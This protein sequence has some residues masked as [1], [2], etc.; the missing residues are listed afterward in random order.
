MND[1]SAVRKQMTEIGDRFLRR[2]IGEV[3]QL[4]ALLQQLRA[5]DGAALKEI[6]IIVHRIHGS[7]AIFGFEA[8]SNAA[9]ECERL[10]ATETADPQIADKMAVALAGLETHLTAAARARTL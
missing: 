3:E 7:G 4:G 8:V 6:E 1:A 9:Y 2:T 10:A 5:G